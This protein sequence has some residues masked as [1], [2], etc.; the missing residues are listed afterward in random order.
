MPPNPL[1]HRSLD[2]SRKNSSSRKHHW[3]KNGWKKNRV[4]AHARRG[5]ERC[6]VSCTIFLPHIFLPPHFSAQCAPHLPASHARP[7]RVFRVF[8]GSTTSTY[9]AVLLSSLLFRLPPLKPLNRAWL[10]QPRNTL[11]TRKTNHCTTRA[12]KAPT[13]RSIPAWGNAPGRWA[14]VRT[15]RAESPR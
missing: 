9:S 5:L 2:A 14:G 3:Q 10:D 7:F 6:R 11:N 4:G 13:A 15:I 8:R 12:L 1:S